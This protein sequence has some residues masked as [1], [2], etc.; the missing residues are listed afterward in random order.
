MRACPKIGAMAHGIATK[1]WAVREI[2]ET[3]NAR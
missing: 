3:A 1:I 2:I